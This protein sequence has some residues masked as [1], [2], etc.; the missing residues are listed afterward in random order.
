MSITEIKFNDLP[1]MRKQEGLVIQ[2]CGGDLKEWQDGINEL[3]TQ[4]NILLD[5][6]KFEDCYFFK[7]EDITCLLF[8]FKEG[9]KFDVS[10]LAMW[11]IASYG[12]LYGKWLSD[13]IDQNFNDLEMNEEKPNCPLIGEDGNIFNLMG[14]AAR[15]LNENGMCDKSKEMFEKITAGAKSYEEALGIIGEYVN[16]TSKYDDETEDLDEGID[17]RN[18]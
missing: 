17:L 13:Y 14:I 1:K 4:D 6:T 18:D 12:D 3:L 8:P 16:I 2:G 9:I 11:R 10:R 5:G 15:T 7:N